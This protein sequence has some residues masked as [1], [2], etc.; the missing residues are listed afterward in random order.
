[1]VFKELKR[2]RQQRD[3]EEWRAMPVQ[4]PHHSVLIK[5]D[6][7]LATQAGRNYKGHRLILSHQTVILQ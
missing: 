5:K 4:V 6:V 1:M 7:C 3:T 2:D